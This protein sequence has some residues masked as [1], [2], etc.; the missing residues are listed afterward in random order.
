NFT[1]KDKDAHAAATIVRRLDGLPLAIELAA[2]RVRSLGVATVD[3]R[4]DRRFDLLA[5]G[6]RTAPSRQQTLRGLI[7]W[8]YELLSPAE[9]LLFC[10]LGIF[11]GG[12]TLEASEQVCGDK[13]TGDVMV[14]LASLVEKSLVVKYEQS[15]TLRYRLMESMRDFACDALAP[16]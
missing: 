16:A 12:W 14:G 8:S 10:R 6:N 15:D 2:A 5:G 1:L 13:R 11:A 9:Q 7:Q 3:Q 4:L